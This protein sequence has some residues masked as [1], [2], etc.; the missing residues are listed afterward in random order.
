MT[1]FTLSRRAR[2]SDIDQSF[3][4]GRHNHRGRRLGLLA[5][6]G[7]LGAGGVALMSAQHT[8]A[9][10]PQVHEDDHDEDEHEDE[11]GS[12][13]AI[14]E[15]SPEGNTPF[16][17]SVSPTSKPPMDPSFTLID[18]GSSSDTETIKLRRKK[19][20]TF[21]L[22]LPDDWMLDDVSCE[23]ENDNGGSQQVNGASAV[24]DYKA[25]EMITCT[26]MVTQKMPSIELVKTAD[27]VTYNGAGETIT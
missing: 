26:W 1:R 25:G 14:L 10:T 20:Y 24:I 12:L 18:D 19:E 22:D 3:P 21:A 11:H 8:S 27:P 2:T 13:T 23:V 4:G 16:V 5:V 15:A 9:A 6:L 17:F 7:L